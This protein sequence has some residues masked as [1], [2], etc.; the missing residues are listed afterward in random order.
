MTDLRWSKFWWADYEG[1]DALRLCSLAAQGLWMRMLCAMNRGQPYGHLAINGKA[2]SSR[3]LSIMLSATEKE[4]MKLIPELTDAGVCSITE[5]GIVYSRRM[6]RDKAIRDEAVRNGRTGGNPT[7]TGRGK[8]GG[9]TPPDKPTSGK[10]HKLESES[11][12]E[13]E[14]EEENPP[15]NGG[16]L[17]ARAGGGGRGSRLPEGWQPA[18]PT[19]AESLGLDHHAV[20]AKFRDHFAHMPD[21]KGRSAN[22]D[23][24][25]RTWCRR[26]AEMRRTPHPG[27]HAPP[28]RTSQMSV[29]EQDAELLRRIRAHSGEDE[30]QTAPNPPPLR[31][32]IP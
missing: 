12:A 14:S 7:L 2:P 19:I 32:V 18:D 24:A 27:R 8:P 17:R 1:D 30:P 20:L 29:A 5:E 11:E 31:L 3:Q 13:A 9:L 23:A 4:V 26:E 25:W 16:G 6:V 10:P 22:W 28:L 15:P 21:P